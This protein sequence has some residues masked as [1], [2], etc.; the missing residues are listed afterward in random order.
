MPEHYETQFLKRAVN[1]Q[2]SVLSIPYHIL[3]G[4]VKMATGTLVNLKMCFELSARVWI[5]TESV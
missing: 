5:M 2:K 4:V 1:F 3:A